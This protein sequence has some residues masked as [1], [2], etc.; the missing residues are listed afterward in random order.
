VRRF[1]MRYPHRVAGVVLVDSVHPHQWF[2]PL[3]DQRS[4]VRQ[5]QL[6][7]FLARLGLLRLAAKSK[8]RR[9]K[10]PAEVKAAH[11]ALVSRG[12]YRSVTAEVRAVHPA[13][14]A[15]TGMLGSLPLIVLTQT[16]RKGRLSILVQRLQAE[17]PRLSSNSQHWTAKNST[18]YIHLDE[19]ELVVR[20]VRALWQQVQS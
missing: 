19:P 3:I 7:S 13:R 12:A 11:G 17:L 16:P 18:H 6:L 4:Q 10:M 14:E 1:A 2:E 20:A 5:Q 15:I 8:F 9:L